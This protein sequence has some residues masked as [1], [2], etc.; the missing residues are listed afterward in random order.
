MKG[1]LLVVGAG[2][3]GYFAAIRAREE[4]PDKPVVLIEAGAKPLRKVAIS[5]GGRCNVTHAC[6]EPSELV[7][8]YPRGAQE[9]RGPFSRFQPKDTVR[10]FEDRG[11]KLKTEADGR[12]FPESD[13]SQTIIDCLEQARSN[14]GVELRLKTKLLQLESLSPPVPS[15]L[16]TFESE[17]EKRREEFAAVVFATGSSPTGYEL[18]KSLGHEIRPCVPSLF[19]FEISD[20]RLKGLAGVSVPQAEIELTL[21]G[22]K[23]LKVH[24]PVLVTHWGL[25]GPGVIKLSAWAAPELAAQDYR[26]EICLNWAPENSPGDM[27]A[28]LRSYKSAHA[29]RNVLGNAAFAFPKRL[30]GSLAGSAGIE[31]DAEWGD[32]KKEQLD[33]LANELQRGNFSVVGKGEFKDEFVTCGGVALREVDF[34]SMESKVNPG[35]FFAGEILD[36]DGITGGYNFQSAWTTGWIAGGAAAAETSS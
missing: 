16:A 5:G 32:I 8:A 25:S 12:I 4:N 9:L 30:W 22:R 35:I 34:R 29:K 17:K 27:A 15:F 21:A 11:V 33:A 28:L 31:D 20:A 36:I 7:R 10:W 18:A 26:A 6:F 24:G 3:A 2:A 13:N 23:P 19:T 1:G 14:V